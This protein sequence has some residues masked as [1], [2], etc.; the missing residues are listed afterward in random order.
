MSTD[1]DLASA[2]AALNERLDRL[3]SK[4]DAIN[5]PVEAS[6]A[7]LPQLADPAVRDGLGQLLERLDKATAMV[8]ALGTLSERLPVLS[9]AAASGAGWAWQQAE[10]AGIDP[11]ATGK[12]AARLSLELAQDDSMALVERLMARKGDLTM[13]LDAVESIDADDLRTVTTQGA[14]LTKKLAALLKAPELARVLDV[15]ADP[16]A[17][18]TVEAAT[19]ALVASR[20]E[21]IEPVGLFGVLGKMGDP[22]VQRAVGLTFAIAKR[23]GQLLDR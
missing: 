23:F 1:A 6:G 15:T 7:G 9:D 10:D 8:D 4:V 17:L 18:S 16:G 3:E 11:L 2:L 22:D 5:R 20:S 12:R 14:A 21:K 13:V 19:T